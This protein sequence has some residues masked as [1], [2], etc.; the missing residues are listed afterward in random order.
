VKEMFYC[1]TQQQ[2]V[3]IVKISWH[4]GVIAGVLI[5]TAFPHNLHARPGLAA[6]INTV[7]FC[8]I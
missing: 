4:C 6:A 8:F 7:L 2:H 5:S 3:V 1:I